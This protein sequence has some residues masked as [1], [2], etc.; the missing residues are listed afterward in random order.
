MTLAFTAV[1]RSVDHRQ[2]IECKYEAAARQATDGDDETG[3]DA[4]QSWPFHGTKAIGDPATA[5]AK[6]VSKDEMM[7]LAA[8]KATRVQP[9]A[10]TTAE[11]L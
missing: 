3:L 2:T 1:Q 8:Q 4:R 7:T 9:S 5:S 11:R 10:C 6:L